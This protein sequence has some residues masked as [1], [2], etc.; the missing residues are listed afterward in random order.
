MNDSRTP[1]PVYANCEEMEGRLRAFV[2]YELLEV[3][4]D[5]TGHD[6]GDEDRRE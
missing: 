3:V 4:C 5:R 1:L 2:P 6:A